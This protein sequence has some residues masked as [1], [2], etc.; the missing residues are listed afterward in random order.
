MPDFVHFHD[1]LQL[2]H[3]EHQRYLLHFHLQWHL[4]VGT[5]DV[6]SVNLIEFC[7]QKVFY[8]HK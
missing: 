8:N 4:M 6:E 2:V 1:V 3:L 5:A 7:E